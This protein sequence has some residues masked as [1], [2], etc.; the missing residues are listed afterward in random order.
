MREPGAP[1]SVRIRDLSAK[2]YKRS[3]D[4]AHPDNALDADWQSGYLLGR[5][6][7]KDTFDDINQEWK[8][9]GKPSLNMEPDTETRNPARAFRIWKAGYWA[10]RFSRL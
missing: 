1:V 5:F 7:E 9:R 8:K 3:A 6:T 4:P 10:G 2:I